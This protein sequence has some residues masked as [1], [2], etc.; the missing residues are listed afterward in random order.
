MNTIDFNQKGIRFAKPLENSGGS[1]QANPVLQTKTATPTTAQQHIEADSGYDGLRAV[2]VEA[3]TAAIDTDITPA[4]IKQ[5]VNILGVTGTHAGID[6]SDATAVAADIIKGKTAYS[7][8]QKLTGTLQS[9]PF[10]RLQMLQATEPFYLTTEQVNYIQQLAGYAYGC[11]YLFAHTKVS[12]I[13]FPLTEITV[14]RVFDSLANRSPSLTTVSFP[15]LTT[16]SG[17]YAFHRAFESCASLTSVSFPN[18]TSVTGSGAFY[19]VCLGC[20]SLTTVSFPRLETV[21]GGNVFLLAFG[22]CVNME[23]H[24]AAAGMFNHNIQSSAAK[25]RNFTL[26]ATAEDDLRLIDMP[27]LNSMSVF[28]VLDRL[29]ATAAGK[30]CAFADITI[31]TSDPNN[32][33]IAAKVAA[34]TNWTITGLTIE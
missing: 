27:L 18:L 8:G 6:T 12:S 20:S 2:D 9:C 22:N 31:A 5:G 21:S 28:G 24:P 26:T 11:Y 25:V 16:V 23:T 30:T 33:A 7:N 10:D 14:E 4:N 32:A 1:G 15:N 19:C 17:Q 29:S 34:L 3:V 13:V